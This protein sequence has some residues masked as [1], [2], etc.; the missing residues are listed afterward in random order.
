MVKAAAIRVDVD[1]AGHAIR[2]EGRGFLLLVVWVARRPFFSHPRLSGWL[3]LRRVRPSLCRGGA[4]GARLEEELRACVWFLSSAV[5]CNG[6]VS[7]CGWAYLV[8]TVS[9]VVLL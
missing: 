2:A 4:G 8:W 9:H 5:I 7:C 1:V 3:R 6:L